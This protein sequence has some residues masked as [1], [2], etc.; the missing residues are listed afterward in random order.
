MIRSTAPATCS[1]M[2]RTGRSMP[3]MSTMV[4]RRER[5]VARGVGVHRGERPVV[6]GVHGL[7]HVEGGAVTD[8]TD[9]DAVGAH[10]QR[11]P[12]EVADLDLRRGP[13][14]SA[15]RDSRR[16]TW[17]WCSWSSA[18]SSMVTMRSS[19]GMNDEMTL[20]S[21]RLARAGAAGD[22]DVAAAAGRTPRG[23]RA[24]RREGAEGDEV[25]VGERVGRELSDGE[26][27]AVEGDRR[28]D[29]VDA[30]AVGQ[31]GVDER[32]RLVDAAADAADDL[33]DDAAQVRLVAEPARR[34]GRACRRARRRCSRRR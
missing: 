26:H 34:P 30:R 6:A 3:A 31:A 28:D 25:G 9:D 8:L 27:R 32:A 15:G 23:S 16:S 7:E 21:R 5:R 17:S 29:G 10:A 24:P 14:C 4:S 19:S 18:A 13:R 20:S 1:R 12:H 33:V 2:A 11:V 22:D